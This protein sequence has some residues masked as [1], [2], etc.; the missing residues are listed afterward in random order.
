MIFITGDTH[1][2]IDI[3]KLNTKSFP[4]QKTLTK[5]DY[6]IIC[7]DFGGVWNNSKEDKNWQKWLTEKPFTTLFV[8]GNHENFE[9]LYEY[10]V[11]DFHNGKAHQITDSIFHLMRGE[12]FNIEGRSF[13]TMGGAQSHDK[14][15]RKEKIDWWPQELPSEEEYKHAIQNLENINWTVDFVLTH[16]IDSSSQTLLAP[17][18]S[19]NDLTKFFDLLDE[20]L[21][22]K[23]WYCG[24]YHTHKS[25]SSSKT[26]LYKQIIQL[27]ENHIC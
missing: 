21:T 13:F 14:E 15:Y 5:D 3:S 25:V 1:I 7:G 10:P 26:V 12:V 19:Q 4:I 23:H 9:L 8:D 6:V 20:K 22:Y 16:C 17:S 18:Y 27:P 11:V 24:H 2:P